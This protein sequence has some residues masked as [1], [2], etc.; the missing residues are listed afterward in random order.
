M[1]QA[2]RDVRIWR[3]NREAPLF[4]DPDAFSGKR[5]IIVAPGDT[6]DA[7]MREVDL[8]EFDYVVRMN[9]LTNATATGRGVGDRA[10]TDILFHNLKFGGDR[11][12]GDLESDELTREGTSLIIFPHA[13]EDFVSRKVVAEIR[14]QRHRLDLAVKMPPFDFYSNLRQDLQ[15]LRPTTGTVAAAFF[16]SCRVEHLMLAGFTFFRTPYIA[17]YNDR[18]RTHV[19]AR[20][21]GKASGRHDPERE[22]LLL[23]E[24]IVDARARGRTISLAPNVERHLNSD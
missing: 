10:R 8:A 24:R 1:R 21:W 6:V 12:A 2:R 18:V 23:R 19:D 15:G 16:L 17:G 14:K 9:R 13:T 20:K 4:V 5:I 11:G 3:L 22:R 7:D